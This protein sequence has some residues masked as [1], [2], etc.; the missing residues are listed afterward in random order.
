M[1]AQ[2]VGEQLAGGEG[3]R[4][5]VVD[6]RVEVERTV[7]EAGEEER[8]G[9]GREKGAEG[10]LGGGAAM[11][12]RRPTTGQRGGGERKKGRAAGR[13]RGGGG[14]VACVRGGEDA[15]QRSLGSRGAPEVVGGGCD[16]GG[17]GDRAGVVA[18]GRRGRQPR[19]RRKKKKEKGKKGKRRK[20]IGGRVFSRFDKNGGGWLQ[21]A[22]GG[23][24]KQPGQD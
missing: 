15:G 18:G 16:V 24:G 21:D 17:K 9:V 8:N 4:P 19:E 3:R 10:E 5:S 11:G 2:G 20:E 7:A 22:G 23:K 14:A 13:A 6:G 1:A 12:K